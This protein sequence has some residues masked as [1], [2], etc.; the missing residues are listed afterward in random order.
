[1]F[2]VIGME[3]ESHTKWNEPERE[4]YI[5]YINAYIWNLEKWHR[6]TYCRAGLETQTCGHKGEGES[7]LNWESC[8]DIYAVHTQCLCTT[9]S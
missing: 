1:M 5:S 4:K 3:P 2:V 7:E 6:G 8:A 9:D